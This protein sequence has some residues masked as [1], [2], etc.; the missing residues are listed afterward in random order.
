[1]ALF[2]EGLQIVYFHFFSL[3]FNVVITKPKKFFK[4]IDL[5]KIPGRF[6]VGRSWGLILSFWNMAKLP[7]LNISSYRATLTDWNPT[8]MM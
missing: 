1:M 8:E 7:Y 4:N 5:K 3:T 6:T 2:D